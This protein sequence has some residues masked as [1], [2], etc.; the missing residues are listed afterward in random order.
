MYTSSTE[1]NWAVLVAAACAAAVAPL[2]VGDMPP[3]TDFGGHAAMADVWLRLPSSPIVARY[4]ERCDDPLAPNLV[5]SRFAELVSPGLDAIAALRV[6]VTLSLIAITVAFGGMAR[7]FRRSL[8]Q[9][10]VAM[11]F[12]WGSVLTLGFVN[13]LPILALIPAVYCAGYRAATRDRRVDAASLL[14]GSSFAYFCHALGGAFVIGF[15][16]LGLT[17]GAAGIRGARRRLRRALWLAPAALLLLRFQ[18]LGKAPTSGRIAYY[19]VLEWLFWLQRELAHITTSG[20]ERAFTLVGASALLLFAAR[21]RWPAPHARGPRWFAGGAVTAILVLPAYLGELAVLGRLVS[22]AAIAVLLLPRWSS[23]GPHARRIAGVAVPLV[24]GLFLHLTFAAHRFARDELEPL[25]AVLQHVPSDKRVTC[26]NV[27]EARPEFLRR[28]L[29]LGCN[30]LAA[31][32][33]GALT[34][35][36][37]AHTGYNSIR[38]RPGV[39]ARRYDD[40]TLT[41]SGWSEFDFV[42]VRGE[43]PAPPTRR[44]VLVSSSKPACAGTLYRLFAVRH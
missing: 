37:F 1:R 27:R 20:R 22:I 18:L 40:P 4:F 39:S 3:L 13:F 6:M 21:S 35:G 33:S 41:A 14:L 19:G 16:L 15:G 2:W 9:L 29:D 8:A 43:T 7:L 5:A 12:L 32:S 24:F 25:R 17:A 26:V 42:I 30:G 38:L 10:F 36:G 23:D 44:A 28:P 11:P 31:V 34:G